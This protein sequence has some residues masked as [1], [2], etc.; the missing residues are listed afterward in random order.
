MKYQYSKSEFNRKYQCSNSE[1]TKKYQYLQ[2]GRCIA[3]Q[4]FVHVVIVQCAAKVDVG[5]EGVV[6]AEEKAVGILFQ[7]LLQTAK[8]VLEG[9]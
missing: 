9:V 4:N 1:F 2:D 8:F 5:V 7:K 3:G 6:R